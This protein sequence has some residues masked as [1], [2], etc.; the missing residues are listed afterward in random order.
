[1]PNVN[2]IQNN[3]IVKPLQGMQ[4]QDLNIQNT[5]GQQNRI[6]QPI[7]QQTVNYNNNAVDNKNT[8]N[9]DTITIPL[10]N[11]EVKKST[12]I[13]G[14]IITG[15]VVI[16]GIIAGKHH[17]DAKKLAVAANNAGSEGQKAGANGGNAG[18]TGQGAGGTGSVED[19]EKAGQETRNIINT[20]N[21]AGKGAA[22][23]AD[24]ASRKAGIDKARQEAGG[25]TDGNS[26]GETVVGGNNNG[27]GGIDKNGGTGAGSR[28]N[29]TD[30]AGGVSR[31]I[32]G[33]SKTVVVRNTDGTGETGSTQRQTG[34]A[35]TIGDTDSSIVKNND[36]AGNASLAGKAAENKEANAMLDDTG[37]AGKISG[38]GS[39]EVHSNLGQEAAVQVD[40]QKATLTSEQAALS[41]AA[42]GGVAALNKAANTEAVQKAAL[43]P[44]SD[45]MQILI[46]KTLASYNKTVEA[47]EAMRKDAFELKDSCE[48]EI[49]KA[50]K[51]VD[52]FREKGAFSKEGLYNIEC[53]DGSSVEVYNRSNE[54]DTPYS[55]LSKGVVENADSRIN[56]EV[57]RINRSTE[58][59]EYID[60]I[61]TNYTYYKKPKDGIGRSYE[62][63]INAN[64]DGSLDS[65]DIGRK[66][67]ADDN[68]IRTTRQSQ[69]YNFSGGR[70]DFDKDRLRF[71]DSGTYC[72]QELDGALPDG[73]F[74]SYG[75]KV[76]RAEKGSGIESAD[77]WFNRLCKSYFSAFTQKDGK[78]PAKAV[79][80]FELAEDSNGQMI[81]KYFYSGWQGKGPY[82]LSTD[83]YD[84]KAERMPDG[85]WV[86]CG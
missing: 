38:I 35:R 8:K 11:K 70:V 18:K 12:A 17:F 54:C 39:D 74:C 21:T 65:C 73:R 47:A 2:G 30:S 56:G 85:S 66:D 26:G 4:G 29:G 59:N 25:S 14:G 57:I 6:N 37:T 10:L 19:I 84:F 23:K 36:S 79:A 16:G 24:E 20:E 77:N 55:E 75:E 32:N 42:A 58:G 69:L 71:N 68:Q 27:S 61:G 76:K 34:D 13:I 31:Q 60:R 86:K 9:G 83:T 51:T 40:L 62:K 15:L 80:A 1:M 53:E 41:A 44:V 22:E 45:E 46:D 43:E 64:S 49:K 3:G 81:P 50:Q 78:G 72:A 33:D 5:N 48:E 28:N 63:I 7:N 52:E 67:Y 82:T